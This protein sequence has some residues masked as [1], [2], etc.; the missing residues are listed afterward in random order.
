MLNQYFNKKYVLLLT[1]L[2][3]VKRVLLLIKKDLIRLVIIANYLQK[4]EALPADDR[5]YIAEV[6]LRLNQGISYL[7]D[8]R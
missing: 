5:T 4:I 3:R 2:P 8:A 6:I 1:N 7:E